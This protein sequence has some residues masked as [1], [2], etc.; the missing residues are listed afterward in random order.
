[1]TF[2]HTG[3][4]NRSRLDDSAIERTTEEADWISMASPN[5]SR[6]SSPDPLVLASK[7]STTP[8]GWVRPLGGLK[9]RLELAYRCCAV[10]VR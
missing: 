6:S 4:L 1:M 8:N 5:S 2:C 10:T 7:V 9:A 3:L